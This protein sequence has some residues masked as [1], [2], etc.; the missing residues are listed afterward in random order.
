[1]NSLR[2]LRRLASSS[3]ATMLTPVRLPPGR[4][5]ESAK[6]DSIQ[7]PVMAT[8]GTELVASRSARTTGSP[9][10]TITTGRRHDRAPGDGGPGEVWQALDIV[11][12]R[13][14]DD[15]DCPALDVPGLRE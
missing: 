3:V 13:Y 7:N 5:S 9:E 10:A 4:D 15:A 6:R 14:A 12:D 2:R 8:I 11:L 1:M